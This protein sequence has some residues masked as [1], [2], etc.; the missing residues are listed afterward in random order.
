[1]STSSQS[2]Y[3]KFKN[4]SWCVGGRHY[5]GTSNIIGDITQNKNRTP[6]KLLKGKCTKCNR[7]KSMTVSDKT[8]EAEGLKDFFKHVGK[9]ALKATKSVGKKVLAN[10][11]RALEIGAQIGAAAASRNP[12]AALAATPD[13]IKFV[14]TGKGLYLPKFK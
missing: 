12:K 11:G 5:S 2:A 1:M 9:A 8:I 6:I 3:A 4:N 13:V 14:H 10:P 7:N